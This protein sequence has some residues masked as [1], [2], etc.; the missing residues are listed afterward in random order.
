VIVDCATYVRGRRIAADPVDQLGPLVP[1]DPP[2]GGDRCAES[3]VWLGL[4]MP[5]EQQLTTACRALGFDDVSADE[6]LRVHSRPVLQLDGDQLQLVVRTAHYDDAAEQIRLGE[7]TVLVGPRAVIT[8]RHGHA[9]PLATL[10]ASLE[11]EPDR[12]AVGPIAVLV[13]VLGRVIDDYRPALDGFE[14]DVVDVERD[15]FSDS[16]RQPV[17]RLYRLKRE[18]RTFLV[19]I[20]A[21]ETPLGRLART[22]SVRRS[23]EVASDLDDVAAQLDRT[24]ARARS[25][26]GLLDAALTASLTQITVQQNEDMRRISAWVAM[27]AVPTLLAGIYGMNFEHVPELGFRYGYP[28]ALALMVVIAATMHRLFRSS[29]WL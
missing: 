8:I 7:L 9:S 3:F 28:A 12:L 26:S 2:T 5:D 29:G 25:L 16:R 6:V 27:A 24:I 13:A 18:V 4:R 1:T 11:R 10:R 23:A 21:L 15:V 14:A 20:E 17:S 22:T 19:A